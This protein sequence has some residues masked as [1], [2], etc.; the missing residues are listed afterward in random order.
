MSMI[1]LGPALASVAVLAVGIA[2]CG[3][4]SKDTGNFGSSSGGA[5]KSSTIS[6]AGS[7]FTAPV[8]RR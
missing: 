5:S 3:G 1:R 6:E 7:T 8:Y 2:A 4:S